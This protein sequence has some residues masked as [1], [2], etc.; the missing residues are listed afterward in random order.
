VADADDHE[1]YLS[2]PAVLADFLA[3]WTASRTA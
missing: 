2:R 3:S 1:V